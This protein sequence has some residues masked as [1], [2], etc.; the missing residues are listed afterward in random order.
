ML[1]LQQPKELLRFLCQPV[2][3]TPPPTSVKRKAVIEARPQ[4]TIDGSD[5]NECDNDKRATNLIGKMRRK[6]PLL[7][8][9][10]HLR[11]IRSGK[12][13]VVFIQKIPNRFNQDNEL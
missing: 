5:D 2:Q 4:T 6:H 8:F 1:Q 11:M 3:L 9:E 13:F 7:F 12:I 10:A